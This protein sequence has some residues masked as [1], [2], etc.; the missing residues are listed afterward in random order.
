VHK[1]PLIEADRTSYP[2][3]FSVVYPRLLSIFSV[4]GPMM[5]VEREA[6]EAA[7]AKAEAGPRQ[8]RGRHARKALLD[9]SSKFLAASQHRSSLSAIFS[10]SPPNILIS[11]F[12][13]ALSWSP[14]E[15][16]EPLSLFTHNLFRH[17]AE[18]FHSPRADFGAEVERQEL[19]PPAAEVRSQGLSTAHIS[20]ARR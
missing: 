19:Q 8:R 6:G 1:T 12:H 10:A 17:H 13:L 3:N 16:L 14:E 11:F 9:V 5:V 20:N 2:P 4:D 15:L 7:G 18:S